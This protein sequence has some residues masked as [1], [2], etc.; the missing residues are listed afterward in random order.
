MADS[1]LRAKF[2]YIPYGEIANRIS[3]G[4]F[5][6]YDLIVTTDTKEALI[7]DS[8]L[9][10]HPIKSKV[11]VFDNKYQAESELNLYTD[12][13]EGQIV[14]VK[15]GD[16]FQAY[17][18]NNINGNY[19]VN[20]IV[21]D[22]D[23]DTLG[24]RPIINIPSGSILNQQQNG[25]YELSGTYKISD[26]DPTTRV[27]TSKILVMVSHGDD[28]DLI[29][30]ITSNQ[31]IDYVVTETTFEEKDYV[32]KQFLEAQGY[33][34]E[35]WVNS[36]IETLDYFSKSEAKEYIKQQIEEDVYGIVETEVTNQ[37]NNSICTEKEIEDL[38]N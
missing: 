30:V 36:K 12:T 19:R 32:T 21:E 29:K 1:A 4:V 10:P 24:N 2:G 33:A 37:I 9:N 27:T 25:I 3:D 38:F 17:I 22:A 11:Y 8:E 31:I 18:V 13:Y 23:Y 6:A 16:K 5:D 26:N 20:H 7:I 15:N 34:T 28:S 14:A 35:N